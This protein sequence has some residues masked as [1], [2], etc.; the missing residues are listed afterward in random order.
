MDVTQLTAPIVRTKLHRL[1]VATDYIARHKLVSNLLSGIELPITLITAPPGY[2]KSMLASHWLSQTDIASA[3]YS[4]DESDNDTRV[5][6]R[7]FVAALR[8]V[9]AN[10]CEATA[11]IVELE[12]L[13][14]LPV[15]SAHLAND[16]EEL[17]ERVV[18]VLD[19]Y[20]R[21]REQE[22]HTLLSDLF[23]HPSPNLHITLVSRRDPPLPLAL[24][25]VNH[26]LSEVRI[27]QL[28][29]SREETQSFIRNATGLSLNSAAIDRLQ[30]VTEGWPAAVRLV[31]L[32][33]K[34]K[35]NVDEYLDHFGAMDGP[36]REY[37]VGEVLS[38][39]DPMMQDCLLK[40]S[41][42]DRFN[43]SLC[44]ALWGNDDDGQTQ[45]N[46]GREFIEVLK[47]SDLFY[48]SL[49]EHDEWFRFHHLFGEMLQKRL[50]ESMGG[51]A[52]FNLHKKA[53]GWLA[54]EGCYEE[55]IQHL[56]A[57]DDFEAAIKVVNKGRDEVMMS[58]R[59]H[60]LE[61]WLRFFPNDIVE[62]YPQLLLLRCWLDLNFWY[63]L[64]ALADDLDRTAEL[65]KSADIDSVELSQ[66]EAE[67][68][69]I[70]SS[71]A[72]WMVDGS[73]T[74]SLTETALRDLPEGQQYVRSIALMFRA[75]GHQLLGE[76]PQAEQLLRKHIE[77][78]GLVIPG[79]QARIMMSLCNIY[80]SDMDIRNLRPVTSRFLEISVSH[81]LRWSF[82]HA[83][84][85]LGL[86]SYETDELADAVEQLRVIVENPY[87]YPIQNITHC[88]FL[89]S[90][91]YQALGW[92]EQ[93]SEISDSICKL[94]IERG[95]SQFIDLAV[96]FAALLDLKQGRV[97]SAYRWLDSFVAGPDHLYH[98]F[99]NTEFT[100]IQIM[101]MR[102]TDEDRIAAAGLLDAIQEVLNKSHHRRLM[103]D[104]LAMKAL[105]KDAQGELDEAVSLLKE[106]ILI[107]EP[108][109][110]I[111]PFADLGQGLI[112]LLNRLD[113]DPQGLEY[114]GMILLALVESDD[115]I[116]EPIVLS[117]LVDSLSSREVEVLG[118][119]AHD[120]SNKEIGERLYISIGT[121]KRHAHNIYGKLGVSCRH[122]AVSKARG[123]GV[124]VSR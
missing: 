118:L 12:S 3:W 18:L 77:N 36:L 89:L 44:E 81:K 67:Y 78:R 39:Q 50:Y 32:T 54:A 28:E 53:A 60:T 27:E 47:N 8:T 16:L 91:A 41:I 95:N 123:L 65:F 76:I 99:Y 51:Q 55:A 90:L 100:A 97:T 69:T 75:G 108:G 37:L 107:G 83:Q 84:Y 64:D 72:Y 11:N 14:P 21:I 34:H 19:D 4:I 1:K 88:S 74:A 98:R 24:L 30:T 114:V 93:A 86:L 109:K 15:V 116:A 70:Y 29:F 101:L 43:A 9:S 85:F 7:Y 62:R 5:F 46:S 22:I 2:G 110:L 103:I 13:P 52:I 87:R 6:L 68:S 23:N 56:L 112:K 48:V 31:T 113:L 117:T 71:L 122:D 79:L 33:L 26:M 57:V 96:S 17:D 40:T 20:H 105:L 49:D 10:A 82:S 66:L 25:R 121:V 120:L 80:W 92:T 115:E 38:A 61:R 42:L 35:K 106:A 45:V 124:L 59:W 119:L 94:S 111:R 58:D 63:R 104:V 73:A 102:D